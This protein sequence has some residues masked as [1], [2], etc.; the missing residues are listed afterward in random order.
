MNANRHH[1]AQPSRLTAEDFA[2]Q[3]AAIA[4][5]DKRI[6]WDAARERIARLAVCSIAGFLSVFL[7]YVATAT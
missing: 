4:A 3:R 1:A 6:A 7:F 2:R 5:Y